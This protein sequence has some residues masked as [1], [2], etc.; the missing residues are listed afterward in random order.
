MRKREEQEIQRRRTCDFRKINRCARRKL[1]LPLNRERRA[2]RKKCNVLFWRHDI[3]CH[4]SG[5][6]RELRKN[7]N[8]DDRDSKILGVIDTNLNVTGRKKVKREKKRREKE[9]K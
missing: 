7:I 8:L 3:S 5:L 1:L 9:K 4:G 2:C 6:A